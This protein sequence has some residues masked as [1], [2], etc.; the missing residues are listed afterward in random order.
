[1]VYDIWSFLGA[2]PHWLVYL[3][4]LLGL[5]FGGWWINKLATQINNLVTTV[6][7]LDMMR[8]DFTEHIRKTEQHFRDVEHIASEEHWKNCDIAKCI[9]LQQIA[10][11]LDQFDRRADETRQNT[12]TSLS[13]LRD[14]QERLS[15]EMGKEIAD[16]AKMLVTITTESMKRR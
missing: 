13:G 10:N 16:L 15:K 1:M 4:A 7:A 12:T 9:H 3:A 6:E 14:G 5:F 2:A 8:G 11:R